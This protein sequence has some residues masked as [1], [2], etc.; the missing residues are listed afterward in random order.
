MIA[1][2][3]WLTLATTQVLIIALI[4][5][6][7]FFN[8]FLKD[9]QLFLFVFLRIST[10]RCQLLIHNPATDSH[11]TIVY[12]GFS[13]ALVLKFSESSDVGWLSIG[14]LTSTNWIFL[15][16]SFVRHVIMWHRPSGF[17]F[18]FWLRLAIKTDKKKIFNLLLIITKSF[19]P[20]RKFLLDIFF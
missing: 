4:H 5:K 1:T 7:Y 12:F 15:R 9:S 6:V 11:Q 19:S 17:C 3:L 16:R 14:E 10:R 8:D 2:L 20:F 13:I 18:D